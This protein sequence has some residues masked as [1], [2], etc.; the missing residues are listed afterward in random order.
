MGHLWDALGS[1]YDALGFADAAD[2]DEVFRQLVLA[3]IIEPT[4]KLDSLR[5]LT[6]AGIAPVSYRTLE[7]A[8][9]RVRR[10]CVARAAGGAVRPPCQPGT[11][12]LAALR[13]DNPVLRDRRR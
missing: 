12:D 13:R 8:P 2:G 7:A 6:E 1:V 4:S 5:V 9:A 3:R 10:R 11:G